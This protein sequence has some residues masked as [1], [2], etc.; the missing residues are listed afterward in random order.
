MEPLKG[1][2]FYGLSFV[3]SVFSCW[4]QSYCIATVVDVN[5]IF[6]ARW[7]T[8]F[9]VFSFYPFS[10]AILFSWTSGLVVMSLMNGHPWH[11]IH[12]RLRA[13]TRG[14]G[15]STLVEEDVSSSF[16]FQIGSLRAGEVLCSPHR[17]AQQ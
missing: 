15:K 16:H 2:Y 12:V 3:T 6:S 17:V 11:E 7:C 1:V 14:A 9:L 13:L 10:T 5:H 4:N 8:V